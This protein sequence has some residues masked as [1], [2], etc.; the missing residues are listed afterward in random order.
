MVSRSILFLGKNKVVY[1][2]DDVDILA[3]HIVPLDVWYVI[4]VG[5]LAAG[6]SPRLYPDE[7]CKSAWFDKSR[8]AWCFVAKPRRRRRARVNPG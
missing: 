8:E 3:A 4:S 2:A 1:T 7:G 6:T 5:A